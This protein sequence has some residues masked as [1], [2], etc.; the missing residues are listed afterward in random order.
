MDAIPRAIVVAID[1]NYVMYWAD[2]LANEVDP[3]NEEWVRPISEG[4]ERLLTLQQQGKLK[5]GVSS[6]FRADMIHDHDPVRKT[7]NLAALEKLIERGVEVLGSTFRFNVGWG[8]FATDDDR[9]LEE[10]LIRI[11]CPKGLRTTSRKRWLNEISDIDHLR[12]AIRASCDV[13]LTEDKGMLKHAAAIAGLGIRVTSIHELLDGY[14]DLPHC[15]ASGTCK[16]D[17]ESKHA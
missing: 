2:F 7:R 8:G 10:R 5:L 13:F 17:R 4:M 15:G 11:V 1:S 3:S 16:Q 14:D 9:S 6:R 12:D